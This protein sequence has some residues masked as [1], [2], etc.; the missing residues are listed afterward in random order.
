MIV[1]ALVVL[2][3][4]I[5]EAGSDLLRRD[6]LP[7]GLAVAIISGSIPYVLE[8]A[9]LRH[10]PTRVFGILMSLE[11]A[12]GALFGYLVLGQRLTALQSVAIVAV[13]AASAGTALS[14]KAA[15]VPQ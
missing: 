11:P 15:P 4:G 3:F 2:P 12:F 14:N 1:A 7:I 13:M 5:L 8:M 9:A 6:V 10:L